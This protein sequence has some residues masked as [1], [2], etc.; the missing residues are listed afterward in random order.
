M[1]ER[2]IGWYNELLTGTGLSDSL[3]V[4][5]ENATIIIITLGLAVLADFLA[6]KNHHC[7]HP[8][9]RQAVQKR[10]GRYLCRTQGI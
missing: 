1:I 8:Q 9:N 2:W 3:V 7:I 6:E 4:I 5:I 10:L